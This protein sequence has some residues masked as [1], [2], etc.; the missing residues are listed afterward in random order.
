MRP[1]SDHTPKP[2][3]EVHGKPLVSWHLEHLANAGIAQVLINTAWLGDH[4]PDYFL[5]HPPVS[6]QLGYSR[7]D[8]ILLG[9]WRQP[10][11]WCGHC[12]HWPIRFGWWPGTCSC[13]ALI[14]RLR[15]LSPLYTVHTWRMCGSCPIP[16][17]TPMATLA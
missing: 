6:M 16:S 2:L 8:W 17:T 11:A 5:A 14:F 3:L 12:Q 4:I 9:H 1:L 10:V 7:E 13:L 15:F